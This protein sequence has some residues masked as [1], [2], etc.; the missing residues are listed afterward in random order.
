MKTRRLG[1]TGFDV[2]ELAFGGGVTGGILVYPDESVRLAALQRAVAAGINLIDTAPTYGDGRSEETIGRCLPLLSPRPRV[3]GKA[4]L[5]PEDL[6]DIEGAIERSL[7]QSL[8]RLRM[9]RIDL[10][11]FHGRLGWGPDEN[12]GTPSLR[13]R[14]APE[15]LLK[16]G[17]VADAFD[18]LKSRGLIGGSGF[19]AMGDSKACIEVAAS[20]RFDTAQVY[21][22]AINPSAAWSRA[23]AGWRS[24]D[25]S[26]LVAACKKNDMGM[27][28]VRLYA[29]GPLAT[30]T[31]PKTL[32]V[33]VSDSNAD[34]ELRCAAAVKNALGDSHGTLAQVALRFVLGNTDFS[35]HVIGLSEIAYLEEALAAQA[36][37]PLPP[38]AMAKLQ[39]L[40]D[41]D[42]KTA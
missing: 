21:Y 39:A 13:L 24:Q 33:M 41:G 14:H 22:N 1:R 17:G 31:L 6:G 36:M 16:K 42:F 15:V 37:G 25:F 2:S 11:Q 40:W 27:L 19:T 38:A 10:L 34:N 28:N 26:G 30:A 7:E 3:S 35:T 4:R 20:G 29:G 5:N 32:L 23:P 9:D 18:K 12:A 8:K